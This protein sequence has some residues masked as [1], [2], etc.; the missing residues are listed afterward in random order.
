[1][2]FHEKTLEL[3]ITHE[4]LNL[5]DSWYWFLTDIPLWRYWRPR[6]RLP[7]LKYP[8]SAA[9]GFHITA[10]G[11]NDATG[12]SGG[13][14]DVRIKSG[15]GNHLLFIQFKLGT[16]VNSSPNL[17]S[18]FNIPPVEHY[19]F[20][21][22]N[23][24]TNQHFLLKE[25][26]KGIGSKTGNAVVYAFPLFGDI[27]EFESHIGK[28]IRRT[29]FISV[30]DIEN[31][32]SQNNVS[33]NR[34]QEHS[35]RICAKDMDRCEVNRFH[36]QYKGIDRSADLIADVIAIRF[37]N[38]LSYFIK[39]I[40]KNYENY[41]LN[42]IYIPEG[43]QR[44][45]SQFIRFILHYFEVSPNRIELDFVSKYF[46]YNI[47][48]LSKEFLDYENISRDIEIVNRIMANLNSFIH[49]IDQ[50]I[51]N[52]DQFYSE[53][54]ISINEIIFNEIPEYKPQLFFPLSS[55]GLNI[56]LSEL[57]QKE[58]ISNILYLLV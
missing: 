38:L 37:R 46:E 40:I 18:I 20:K 21:I 48:D 42:V 55:D 30:A 49:F 2:L 12:E 54:K 51:M 39:E 57:N 23:T 32:A 24:T 56:S 9:S 19:K 31:Q 29:K 15:I 8:K 4:L 58:D 14:Y 52:I 3:N 33:I 44:S 5:A 27:D 6:Y 41:D 1:M 43:I 7:F 13:G 50:P 53:K 22:N 16:Y 11:K 10:E 17:N 47:N 28:L 36:F 45:F 35:F 25:L 34:N 26:S